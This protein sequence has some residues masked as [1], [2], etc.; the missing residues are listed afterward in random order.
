M[1]NDESK[2]E[3]LKEV[4]YSRNSKLPDTLI[5]DLEK[6]NT[7]DVKQ[8]WE[9]EPEVE[10]VPQNP[11]K[12]PMIFLMG[13][14]VFF[15][16]SILFAL[17]MYF[18]G[19]NI[20]S[21]N[22]ITIEALGPLSVGAGEP[23]VVEL[24]VTNNNNIPLIL[25][26]LL[27]EYPQGTRSSV[28]KV[29]ELARERIPIGTIEP[30]QTIR[31]TISALLFDSEGERPQIAY[32]LKYRLD[33]SGSSFTSDGVFTVE[34]GSSPVSLDVSM[35]KEVNADQELVAEIQVTSNSNDTVKN[36][37]LNLD[38]PAGF[39]FKSSNPQPIKNKLVWNLGDI[40]PQG[41]R[42]IVLR[43]TII[44]AQ[45]E[46]KTFKFSIGGKGEGSDTTIEKPFVN[47][48]KTVSI[49]QPFLAIDLFTNG[50]SDTSQVV[51]PGKVVQQRID[52][53]NNLKV[54]IT[55]ASIE[56]ILKGDMVLKQ[57]VEAGSALYRSNENKITWTKVENPKLETLAP[58]KS[59]SIIF[60]YMLAG[61]FS[62]EATGKKNQE[63][64]VDVTV[65][66]K[67]LSEDNV[68]ETIVSTVS[69]KLKL[70]S[71]VK[72]SNKTNHFEGPFQN[73]GVYPP[74]VEKKTDFA[75]TWTA[76]NSLNNLDN[77]KIEAILP[78]YVSWLGKTTPT[79]EKVFY[80]PDS[81]KVTW[82]IGKI[83]SGGG[84]SGS[85]RQVSFQLGFIPSISQVGE[86]PN[87]VNLATFSA[88]D[89]FA[90]TDIKESLKPS[91][92]SVESEA[93]FEFGRDNV[94]Q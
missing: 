17:F 87:L 18:K 5:L 66:G 11:K 25:T 84:T 7:Q 89:T 35:V 93:N 75:V 29:T 22:N 63:V 24:V 92:I 10:D 57:S 13:A 15:V 85:M 79:A 71:E 61:A 78:S 41:E 39:E 90:G 2:I 88:R 16:A 45:S 52:L 8:A 28:D 67:R 81:R 14:S 94:E 37:L 83:L 20:I 21:S 38:A 49:K 80:D 50:G 46:E 30:N 59:Q 44:G 1:N 12:L 51:L 48:A 32:S 60:T 36:L 42:K 3:D 33:T 65:R 58:G 73:S 82:E 4:L 70:E 69:R 19:D 91:T 56:V 6:H 76:T 86:T 55:D 53:Q 77:A 40:E 9:K 27:I 43:G 26:D 54:P 68:P 31:K 23:L 47:L 62:G 72:V 34:I 74:K 64:L